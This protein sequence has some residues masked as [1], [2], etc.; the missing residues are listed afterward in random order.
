MKII[1]YGF[2]CSGNY[3]SKIDILVLYRFLK[4]NGENGI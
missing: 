4:N 1:E 2:F 3:I